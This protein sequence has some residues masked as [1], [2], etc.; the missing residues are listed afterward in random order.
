MRYS[1]FTAA[2]FALAAPAIAQD[3]TM[4]DVEIR[5]EHV[6]PGIAV[7]FGRGGNIGVSYGE[8]GT[9]LI[10]DQYA[11]LT[12]RIQ[13]AIAGLG[14]EPVRFLINTHW[15][16]DHSGG[17]ENFGEAGALIMAHDNVRVR[18]AT[19]QG[20]M[21][22]DT[23]PSPAS[24]LPVVTYHDGV[25]LHLNG[26]TLHAMHM[27]NGH[28]DGDSVIWWENANVVHMGDLFFHQI[29]LPFIDRQ[30]GGSVQGMLAAANRVLEMTNEDTR[31]IPGH[32]PMATRADLVAYRD[33]LDHVITQVGLA[34]EE[35]HSPEEVQAMNIAGEYAVE[36]GFIDAPTF[37]G[38]VYDSLTD[39]HAMDHHGHGHG[40]GH[41]GS[42]DAESH[43]T[44]HRTGRRDS[45]RSRTR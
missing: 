21:F 34:I 26:D 38:F 1:F 15:H 24:A 6:A 25:M 27:H 36:G 20:G 8:D 40:G 37:V 18:M 5:A 41:D 28:T 33:M 42:H 43:T 13:A 17:N 29:S 7:L 44:H 45:L 2:V 32:G 16:G 22:A 31:I 11:P 10:D 19:Q 35:G 39:P 23:P 3:N 12:E 9:V 4:A 14:A 30:S